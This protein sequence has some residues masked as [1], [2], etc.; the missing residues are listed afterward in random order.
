MDAPE[1]KNVF[2]AGDFNN[3]ELNSPSMKKLK[4]GDF[5]MQIDLQPGREYQFRYLLNGEQWYNDW[6]ADAYVPGG[7]GGENCVVVTPV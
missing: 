1:A 3:W 7:L 2:L 6:Y 4:N 5:T